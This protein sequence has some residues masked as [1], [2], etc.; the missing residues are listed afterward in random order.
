MASDRSRLSQRPGRSLGQRPGQER[1]DH[2]HRLRGKAPLVRPA[3][4][5]EGQGLGQGRQALGLEPPASGRWAARALGL[6]G[7]VDRLRQAATIAARS[8][9][10]PADR[11]PSWFLPPPA[12]LR[13][14]VPGRKPVRRATLY[15][16]ALGIHDLHLNGQRVS[17]DYFNPGWTDYTK[18]VYYRAYDVT[19]RFRPGHNAL[20]AI[21][22]DGWYSGY[23]GFGKHAQP[24]RQAPAAP[25][26]A[27]PRVH[28][29]QHRDRRHRTE[30]EGRDRARSVEA[31]FLMGETYDAAADAA[32]LGHGRLRRLASWDAGRHA[33]AEL[34][35]RRPGPSRPAR[36]E[37]FAEV[38]GP[39]RSPSRSRASTCCDLGQN[40][41]GVPRLKIHGEPGQKITLRFAE[42]LNPDGT[43]YTTNLRSRPLHRHLHL[44]RQGRGDLVAPVHVSRLPVRRD[45]RAEVAAHGRHGHRALPSRSD[46]PVVGRFECSDPMLNKLHSNGYWTQRANFID[47]PD[48]LP[49]A[50]R[51][52][53]LD[54]RRPGLHPH[55]HAQLRRPGVLHQVAGRPDRR[56]A[57]R[58]PVPD[59]RPGQGRRR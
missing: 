49:P 54:R 30:L 22:A 15:T 14:V 35:P 10:A 20:G 5:L 57:A 43:I 1:R 31:D 41:A 17:D 18:R 26:P 32:W 46:T 3:V 42:R 11:A 9:P 45:H 50:R 51:A 55:G 56:P 23:V 36:C 28:R 8:P 44:S 59:G 21:L 52:A 19:D 37:A 53:G 16:T 33:G 2:R 4:L 24:L 12:Y 29:R 7:R 6:E 25:S 48:R 38:R 34:K 39:G 40:F 58:R 47:I 13:H 27:S